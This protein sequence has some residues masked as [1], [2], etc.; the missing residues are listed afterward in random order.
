MTPDPLAAFLEARLAETEAAAKAV[1]AAAE[2]FPN[3]PQ[4][5]TPLGH[6]VFDGTG[7]VVTHDRSVTLP[8]DVARH[9]ALHDPARALREVEA[10]RK[11]LAEYEAS[12]RSVGFGLSGQLRRVVCYRA[13][14]WDGHPDYEPAVSWSYRKDPWQP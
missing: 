1:F 9:I 3:A 11:L 8:S 4:R 7:I 6:Q 13:A 14:V 5:S 12:V 2:L 10:D